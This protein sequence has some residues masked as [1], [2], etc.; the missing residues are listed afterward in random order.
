MKYLEERKRANGTKFW[1]FN[2]SV[3]VR[4]ALDVVYKPFDDKREA[5][6]YCKRIS[7]DFSQHR[8]TKNRANKDTSGV[9][10]NSL[11][12]WYI[13]HPKFKNLAERSRRSYTDAFH[14]CLHITS[15]RNPTTFGERLAKNIS[16]DDADI[17]YDKILRQYSHHRANHVVKVLRRAWFVGIRGNRVDKNPFAKM[18]TKQTEHRKYQWTPE[19]VDLAIET[20]D[21]MNLSSMG[22]LILMQYYLCARPGDMRQLTYNSQ[23]QD[24]S[25]NAYKDG[26]AYF[27]QEKT[28]RKN[29]INMVLPVPDRLRERL[30]SLVQV[31]DGIIIRNEKTQQPYDQFFINKCFQKIRLTAGLPFELQMR[32]LR[33]SGAT[34]LQDSSAT[35]EEIMSI[36]GHKDR[37]M[38]EIYLNKNVAVAQNAMNKRFG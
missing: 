26:V 13:H 38:L 21:K 11:I 15:G 6:Q 37:K 10:V 12:Q 14:V 27:Q 9:T 31:D 1:A 19:Q 20:A 4:S 23:Y 7:E 5:Q 30:D 33:R 29:P 16:Y 35:T 24:G 2:P 3:A 28:R 8:R 18:G 25:P 34:A 22:T 32:D 36:T 17:L